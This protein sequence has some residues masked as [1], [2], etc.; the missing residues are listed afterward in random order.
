MATTTRDE[1]FNTVLNQADLNEIAD[2][3][4]QMKFGDMCSPI[5][6]TV[7]GLTAASAI[8]ITTAAVKAA[9]TVVGK[10]LA[11]GEN[12]PAIGALLALRVT[13]SGTGGSL[14]TYVFTDAGGTAI[15]PPGGASAAVGIAKISDDGKT[16]TF[17]NTI[18]AFVLEYMPRAAVDM[19]TFYA[20]RSSQ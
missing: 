1:T 9:A 15:V 3:L 7:T 5:K 2:A 13:A 17:P 14:G 11:T 8:D 10:T 20:S 19:T 6:I 4:R 16:I 18:T 12:L